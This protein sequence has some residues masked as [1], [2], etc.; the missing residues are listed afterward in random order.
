MVP[1]ST[2]R[3]APFEW[4]RAQAFDSGRSIRI[5]GCLS[6]VV[7][8][9]PYAETAVDTTSISNSGRSRLWHN[10]LVD[11]G[12]GLSRISGLIEAVLR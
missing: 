2:P 6:A 8:E 3:Q 4:M 10:T 5:H 7:R 1:L 9:R 11:A 12:Y